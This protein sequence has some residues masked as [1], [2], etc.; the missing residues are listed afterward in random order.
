MAGEQRRLG[1]RTFLRGAGVAMALPLLEAMQQPL[2]AAAMR[3]LYYWQ[4]GRSLFQP[5][6]LTQAAL[7][8]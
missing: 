8:G 4:V 3:K 7:A 5:A 1:R 2:R 6:R